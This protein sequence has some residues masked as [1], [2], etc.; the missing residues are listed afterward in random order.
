MN[1]RQIRQDLER[2]EGW[3]AHAYQDHLGFW[4][5]GYGFLIDERR[6]GGLPKP[7]ADRWLD[8]ILVEIGKALD[9]RIPWWRYQPDN[10][11][12]ALVNQAYQLGVNGL[13]NFRKMLA[14]LQR[15]DRL[16]AA[17]E[18]LN[19]RWA[20]QT[21]ARARRVAAWIGGDDD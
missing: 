8:H 17:A 4:T 19:S 5:I 18:A 21:P 14:A 1:L 9:A 7:I 13:L 2:D 16:E 6:G 12:R 20:A 3:R 15:G 10:V 11:Q